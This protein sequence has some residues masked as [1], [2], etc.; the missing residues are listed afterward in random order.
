M[1]TEGQDPI[2]IVVSYD[3]G[4]AAYVAAQLCAA[5]E[6]STAVVTKNP[7]GGREIG[8]Y[9]TV[10]EA[11]DFARA[12]QALRKSGYEG[13]KVPPVSPETP[14]M[15]VGERRAGEDKATIRHFPY[16]H[17]TREVAALGGELGVLVDR[18]KQHKSRVVLGTAAWHKPVFHPREPLAVR[19]TLE[20]IGPLPIVIG[21]PLDPTL[22]F[23]GLNLVVWGKADEPGE[24]AV[25]LS[26]IHL[27]PPPG[28]PTG[29]ELTLAPGQSV[30][31]LVEKQVYLPPGQY[32]GRLVYLNVIDRPGDPQ[33]VGGQLFLDLGPLLIEAPNPW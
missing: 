19:V 18:I 10:L 29:G 32:Q 21:N 15:Y 8:I 2:A 1:P 20:S 11:A 16:S 22:E 14:F 25:S 30:S 24:Q 27:R 33:F 5:P 31:F 4:Y 13:V 23:V 9:Q 7:V 3:V 17:L 12:L 28:A 6:P 26:P